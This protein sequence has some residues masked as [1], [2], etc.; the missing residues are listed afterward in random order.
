MPAYGST[1]RTVAVGVK[2]ESLFWLDRACE[3]DPDRAVAYLNLGDVYRKLDRNA[4]AR[5]AY[6]K[7]LE[8]APSSTSASTVRKILDA[9]PQSP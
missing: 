2:D 3:I 5:R 7:Y 8:L 4:G 6:K 1:I 9:L